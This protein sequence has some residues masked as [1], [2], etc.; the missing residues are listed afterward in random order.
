MVAIKCEK[1][2]RETTGWVNVKVLGLDGFED[3]QPLQTANN[4]KIKSR[5]LSRKYDL[6]MKPRE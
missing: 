1:R 5:A 6:K 3:A 2:E 4:A